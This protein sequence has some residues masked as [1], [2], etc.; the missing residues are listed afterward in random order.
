METDSITFSFVLCTKSSL[1]LVK[2]AQASKSLEMASTGDGGNGEKEKGDK[3]K[4]GESSLKTMAGELRMNG[5]GG[6]N[7]FLAGTPRRKTAS[8]GTG[9]NPP[10]KNGLGK[11]YYQH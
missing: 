10:R 4:G 1:R 11:R 3:E 5:R 2:T 7:P 8:A 6:T 9:F